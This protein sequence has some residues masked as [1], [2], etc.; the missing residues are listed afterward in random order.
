MGLA[1]IGSGFGRTGTLSLKGALEQLGFGP[2]HHMEE[3]FANPPQVA[4]WTAVAS[5]Q[6]MDW[7]KVFGGYGAQVDWPGAHVWRELAIAYPEAK[8]IHSVRS[9]ESWWRSFSATIGKFMQEYEAMPLP[10]HVREMCD[11][12][13]VMIGEQTFGG[14]FDDKDAAL[15]AYR[16]RTEE[17][18][19]RPFRPS[20]CW[21]SM[22]RKAGVRSARSWAWESRPRRSR[23]ST[24]P[25]SSGSTSG[26]A[27]R[28]LWSG[29]A[30]P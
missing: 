10:P 6:A 30:G 22:S 3:V 19:A 11:A 17:V 2:C 16:R 24:T 15:A 7:G 29:R 12:L 18:C 8:V 28:S 5:G 23:T 9:E 14:A 21:S 25:P 1:V 20:G 27:R 4:N 26:P 13:M